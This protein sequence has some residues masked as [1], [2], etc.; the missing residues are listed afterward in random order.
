MSPDPPNPTDPTDPEPQPQPQPSQPS[1]RSPA[2]GAFPPP[3]PM[4]Q[5]FPAPTDARTPPTVYPGPGFPPSTHGSS[6]GGAGA[7]S[8][9]AV[10]LA[11]LALLLAVVALVVSI[12]SMAA[13]AV[14]GA[15]SYPGGSY[16]DF[17]DAA[18]YGE[19]TATTEFS[20]VR[21]IAGLDEGVCFDADDLDRSAVG[22]PVVLACDQP[23]DFEVYSVSTLDGGFPGEDAVYD[24]TYDA[25]EDEFTDFVGVGYYESVAE[26]G[27]LAP[28]D[29][30]WD[31]GER[32]VVCFV[33]A[34]TPTRTGTLRDTRD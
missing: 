21:S 3:S 18:V 22:I 4:P 32:A 15:T 28:T 26:Y 17:G 29:A 12:S 1:W 25:C 20:G 5:P 10:V 14:L 19:Y 27:I 34:V 11:S 2:G 31:D 8:V 16:A 7:V 9:V 23:H 13:S 24:E 33:F 30:G 6:R